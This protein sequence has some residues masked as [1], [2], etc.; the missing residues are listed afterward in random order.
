MND[1]ERTYLEMLQFNINVD[2]SVY[3]MYYFQLRSLAEE[4]QR[5]FP[6]EPMTTSQAAKLEASAKHVAEAGVKELSM[7]GTLMFK[8]HTYIWCSIVQ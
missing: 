6:L 3:T 5:P 4:A 1:L 2:S 8:A 7:R